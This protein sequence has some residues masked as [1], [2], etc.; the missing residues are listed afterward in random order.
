MH[1]QQN[2]NIHRTMVQTHIWVI[3]VVTVQ[4]MNWG[5]WCSGVRISLLQAT[6]VQQPI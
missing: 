6:L 1:G 3:T 4:S 2:I 5:G